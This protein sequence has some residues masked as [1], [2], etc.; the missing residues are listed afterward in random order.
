MD[1]TLNKS[2]LKDKYLIFFASCPIVNG[3]NRS[4]ICDLDHGTYFTIE[5]SDYQL[6]KIA[7]EN[8]F[9]NLFISVESNLHT[10]IL[11]FISY[12]IENEIAFIGTLEEKKRFPEINKN[13]NEPSIIT[14]AIVDVN[15]ASKHDWKK[16]ITELDEL[17]CND[18]QIRFF[19]NMGIGYIEN[20]F[21]LL[22]ETSIK[23]I[24]LILQYDTDVED[25]IKNKY[26]TE[27]RLA[28]CRFYNSAVNSVLEIIPSKLIVYH[29]DKKI[30]RSSCGVI[31]KKYFTVAIPFYT[32]SLHHNSCLNRKI[33]IDVNGN[34]K[35]CPSMS[36]SYGNIR[37]T[38][39]I[40]IANIVEFKK[41]WSINKDQIKTCKDCEFRYTCSD[42]RAYLE[43]PNDIYS[44]PLKCG[45]DPYTN[46]WEEWSTNL[47]KQQT[48]EFY[49]EQESL[50]LTD[51]D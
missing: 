25:Y 16:I 34:I 28:N 18:L 8:G 11:S 48:F 23:N 6:L 35:N 50:L 43:S 5:N 44:K 21:S 37:D 7:S 33:S 3:A 40:E 14:N 51:A 46:Q 29:T 49:K 26:L 27:F 1:L 30:N 17:T 32:E 10:Y 36:K 4:L 39:L 2:D 41:V 19:S 22:A 15:D 24:E 47:L 31:D 20:I 45:Y 12:L 38:S 42:C 9:D 13:W